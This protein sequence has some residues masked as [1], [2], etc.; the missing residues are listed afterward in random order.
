MNT[1]RVKIC[2]LTRERDVQ[3]AVRAGA[4]ALGFVFAPGSKRELSVEKAA[5]LVS[6]VPAFVTRVGL[7]LDQPAEVVRDILQQVPLNLL[8]F[9]GTE[10]GSYCRQFGWPYIKAVSMDSKQ[11]V[12]RIETEFHDA[13]GLL[14]DSHSP[15]GLGGTG[16]VFDWRQIERGSHPTYPGGWVKRDNVAEAVRLVQPWG[17]DVSSGVEDAPGIK[18]EKLM[19]EFINRGKT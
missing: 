18:N 6:R 3:C 14:L 10:E 7:F 11:A 13:A 9:H 5:E 15:G 2:G 16:H 19:C 8:Q 17:V 12:D 1:P 4:D